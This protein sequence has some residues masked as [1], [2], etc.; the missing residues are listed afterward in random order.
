MC[1]IGPYKWETQS[2]SV[3][4]CK[5]VSFYCKGRKSLSL[6]CWHPFLALQHLLRLLVKYEF[7]L[8]RNLQYVALFIHVFVFMTFMSPLTQKTEKMKK[9]NSHLPP[10]SVRLLQENEAFTF[11]YA[12][13]PSV[14]STVAV[15][16]LGL[17]DHCTTG[18]STHRHPPAVHYRSCS[19]L[20]MTKRAPPRTREH[21]FPT[22]LFSKLCWK[23]ADLWFELGQCRVGKTGARTLP[24]SETGTWTDKHSV[25]ERER[26]PQLW[27]NNV[28]MS[29][30]AVQ[31]QRERIWILSELKME[32]CIKLLKI[33]KL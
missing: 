29:P 2:V 11:P 14:C 32:V 5:H 19:R 31:V 20:L 6:M 7:I 10:I 33:T 15:V 27:E 1:S 23:Y 28:E 26:L 8:L 4:G 25:R 24:C 17:E 22:V 21:G 12:N 13:L 18:D 3:S 16:I 30:G 9:K